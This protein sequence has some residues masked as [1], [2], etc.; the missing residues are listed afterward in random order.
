MKDRLPR[1]ECSKGNSQSF[2]YDSLQR[3][4]SA[5]GSYGTY[6]YMYDKDGNRLTQT[7]GST[8]T[9][10]G[11]GT[12]NDLLQTMSVSGSVTQ[13][14]GYTADGRMAVISATIESS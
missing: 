13:T 10:Y 1:G 8:T 4:S 7:L 5:T 14:V 11:Y 9:T 12:G 2:V 3:L 6:G